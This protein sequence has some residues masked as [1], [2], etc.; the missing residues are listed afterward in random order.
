MTDPDLANETISPFEMAG[1]SDAPNCE[2]GLC[3][4]PQPTEEVTAS[5]VE[6]G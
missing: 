1:S 3:A 5:Q 4:L 6:S 2:S